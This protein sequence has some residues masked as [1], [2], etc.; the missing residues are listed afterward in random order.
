MCILIYIKS[1]FTSESLYFFSLFL[2]LIFCGYVYEQDSEASYDFIEDDND[3]SPK[4]DVESV[5][6]TF[7][8]FLNS[9]E[10]ETWE[11]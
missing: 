8:N 3:P 4:D 6:Y 11:N 9:V 5:R 7:L 10:L 1:R 2:I